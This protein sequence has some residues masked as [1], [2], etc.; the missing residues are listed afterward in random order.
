MTLRIKTLL[1]ISGVLAA[2]LL[3]VYCA[4]RP[5]VLSEFARV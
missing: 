5:L 2:L 1:L 4:V 3:V